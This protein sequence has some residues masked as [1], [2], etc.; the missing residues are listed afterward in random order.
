MLLFSPEKLPIL[1][2]VRREKEERLAVAH[3]FLLGGSPNRISNKLPFRRQERS[4][5]R[6]LH[7]NEKYGSRAKLVCVSVSSTGNQSFLRVEW[8]CTEEEKYF[9]KLECCYW[10]TNTNRSIWKRICS[11]KIFN[12]YS[13]QFDLLSEMYIP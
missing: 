2:L 6:A 9:L 4:N 7:Q 13:N 10:M 11:L 8:V 1:S 3:F 12:I 5:F